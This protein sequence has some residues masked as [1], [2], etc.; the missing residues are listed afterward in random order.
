MRED[1]LA[2]IKAN[3]AVETDLIVTIMK[4]APRTFPHI[5]FFRHP[6]SQQ[7]L[8]NVLYVFA[9]THPSYGYQQGMNDVC[10]IV[11]ALVCLDYFGA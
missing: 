11:Y 1:P 10:A 6:Q 8:I 3:K 9:K 4:D 7:D 5:A 2:F